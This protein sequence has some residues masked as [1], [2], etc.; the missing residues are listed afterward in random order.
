MRPLLTITFPQGFQISKN[1]GHPTSGSGGKKT[2]KRYLRSEQTYKRTDGRTD[3]RTFRLI[4][5]I[6]RC[7]ENSM[8]ILL[9]SC[10]YNVKPVWNQ[11]KHIFLFEI[12]DIG[13]FVATLNCQNICGFA[14]LCIDVGLKTMQ[15]SPPILSHF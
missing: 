14:R 6:G 8:L 10:K 15:L 4:E 12:W 11:Y 5:S 13:S 9:I 3:G 2:V 1:I 7:F